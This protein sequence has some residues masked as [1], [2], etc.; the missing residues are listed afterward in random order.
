MG[1]PRI[2]IDKINKIRE[3]RMQGWS[4]P[5][6][7]RELN[8]GHGTVF[9]Y[10]DGVEILPEYMGIWIQ[11]RAV[12]I[13]RKIKAES[14]ATELAAN[15]LSSITH[16]ERAVFLSALYWGEGSKKDL[17]FMN[18]DPEMV[19]VFIK[20]VLEVF[21]IAYDRIR[22]SIRIF[23]DLDLEEC[24]AFWSKVTGVPSIEFLTVEIKIGSKSGK[25][26]YGMCRV[27]ILKGNV[28]L[29]TIKAIKDRAVMLF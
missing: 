3:L 29:K 8:I 6:I 27:R 18:S 20:G 19:R 4:L 2:P 16:R 14:Q 9:R 7:K 11:K 28:L 25:L 12:S 10:I 24:L 1:K 13:S 26:R 17:N 21:D 15:L 22:V 5:E 23:E